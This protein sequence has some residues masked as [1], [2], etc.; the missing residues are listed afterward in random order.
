L[1][2]LGPLAAPALAQLL[3]QAPS[4]EAS[5]RADRLLKKSRN[6]PALLRAQRGVE[7]LERLGTADARRLLE[8]LAN[9][10][11]EAWLT[12]EARAATARR[13]KGMPAP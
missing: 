6:F 9:G 4:A 7:V 8:H 1:E 11:A 12:Q 5:R 3:L 13:A 2:K 10:P